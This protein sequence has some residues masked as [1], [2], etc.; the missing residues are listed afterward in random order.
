[1][2][3]CVLYPFNLGCFPSLVGLSQF[4][5]AFLRCI[6]DIRKTLRITGL[7][8]TISPNL[9]WIISQFVR[10]RFIITSRLSNHFCFLKL[11]GIRAAGLR[12]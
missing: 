10:P 3:G 5:H 8:G 9:P 2:V 11:H 7:T 1:M 12:L 6:F 4:L